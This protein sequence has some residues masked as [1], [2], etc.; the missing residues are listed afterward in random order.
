MGSELVSQN[1]LEKKIQFLLQFCNDQEDALIKEEHVEKLKQ[2]LVRRDFFDTEKLRVGLIGEF[3]SGKSTLINNLAGKEV[4][5]TDLYEMTSWIAWIFSTSQNGAVIHRKDGSYEA[6]DLN[7]LQEKCTSRDYSIEELQKIEHIDIMRDDIN[8]DF[9]FID[10]PGLGSTRSENEA[11]MIE[12]IGDCDVLMWTIDCESLGNID[13]F[14]LVKQL[15]ESSTP[16]IIV[17]TKCDYLDDFE[18]K[19]NDISEYITDSFNI[20]T[21]KIFYTNNL[22]SG[23]SNS[24][25]ELSKSLTNDY[26]VQTRELRVSASNAHKKRVE[27][28]VDRLLIELKDYL[29]STQKKISIF[30]QRIESVAATVYLEV[31][32]SIIKHTESALFSPTGT[33]R[34]A[35]RDELKTKS[36]SEEKFREIIESTISN[37][38]L[39]KFLSDSIDIISSKISS[40]WSTKLS[41][42]HAEFM[43][44]LK[45]FEQEVFTDLKSFHNSVSNS[46]LGQNI[47]DS[48]EGLK[49]TAG[50]TVATTAYAAFLGPLAAQLTFGAAFTLVGI[51]V[52]IVG[53]AAAIV[54]TYLKKGNV[55]KQIEDHT[56]QIL[57]DYKEMF[58]NEVVYKKI[59][60][61]LRRHND[62]IAL[63]LKDEFKKTIN[64]KFPS[65][66]IENYI[67]EIK[68]F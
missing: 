57:F 11:K 48:S 46:T 2:L 60:P 29:Q 12:A 31:Q 50:A 10:T 41:N 20:D 34:N 32:D 38:K 8:P 17:I 35:I 13:E 36:L 51:P 47:D 64:I 24:T 68:S 9:V 37:S 28:E 23:E 21:S 49:L 67:K 25:E 22:H 42:Y 19:K 27:S 4:A 33:F 63:E 7:T 6:I 40:E 55:A 16:L 62:M 61:E 45:A 58:N 14:N 15:L 53:G 66:E 59:L 18:N 44:I 5:P 43:Q 30:D 54:F 39:E 56:D 65:E 1:N 52:A 26:K 3:K